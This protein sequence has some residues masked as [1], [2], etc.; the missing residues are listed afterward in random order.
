MASTKGDKDNT[1]NEDAK[2]HTYEIEVSYRLLIQAPN[3]QLAEMQAWQS[4]LVMPNQKVQEPREV[5]TYNRSNA[6]N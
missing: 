4:R 5:L 1:M 3:Q 2:M 6:I